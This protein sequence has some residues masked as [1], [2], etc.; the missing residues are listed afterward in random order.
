VGGPLALVRDGDKILLDVPNRK[1]NLQ[2]P[3]TELASRRSQWNR[4]IPKHE[5]AYL[6]IYREHVT[7]ANHGC[8]FSF[9]AHPQP[10]GQVTLRCSSLAEDDEQ[11]EPA[12]KIYPPRDLRLIRHD[13]SRFETLMGRSK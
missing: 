10:C 6:S 8:D 2:V 1:L 7:Q 9:F 4:P 13:S 5:S 3:E 11:E 12:C